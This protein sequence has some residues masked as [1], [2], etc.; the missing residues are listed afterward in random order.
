M[1]PIRPLCESVIEA[2]VSGMSGAA[3]H[4]RSVALDLALNEDTAGT[5]LAA[6]NDERAAGGLQLRVAL[7]EVIKVIGGSASPAAST[8]F[9]CRAPEEVL[10]VVERWEQ[11]CARADEKLLEALRREKAALDQV[12][13]LRAEV[14][15]KNAE[16]KR[17]N[18]VIG[19]MSE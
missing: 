17:L 1:N 4:A 13:A 10:L 12:E 5:L 14:A 19:E 15:A 8:E 2:R 7:A 11:K 6:L 3:I 18:E 16:I 9:L